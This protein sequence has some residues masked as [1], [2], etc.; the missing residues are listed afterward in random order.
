MFFKAWYYLG[1]VLDTLSTLS[2]ES[3]ELKEEALQCFFTATTLEE[4]TPITPF[5]EI[6]C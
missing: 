5:S 2:D 1:T 4:A 3:L 6:I